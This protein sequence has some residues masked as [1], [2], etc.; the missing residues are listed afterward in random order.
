MYLQYRGDQR[1]I[2]EKYYQALQNKEAAFPP[3]AEFVKYALA[4]FR[5]KMIQ[6][7]DQQ[8]F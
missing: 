3:D 7:L 5:L 6:L 1:A 4:E 8:D 2:E